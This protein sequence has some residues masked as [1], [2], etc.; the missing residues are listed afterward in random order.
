[1]RARQVCVE[2]LPASAEAAFD[3]VHDY[4]RR[5][6]WDTLL[7]E[8]Y[9]EDGREPGVGAVAS[10]TGRWFVGGLCFR[11]VYVSF[12]R[13]EVAAVKLIHRPPFFEAWAASIRHEPLGP[14]RSRILYT[15][16]FSSRP[17]FLAWLLEPILELAFRIETRRRLRALRAALSQL[18]EQGQAS[19]GGRD[20]R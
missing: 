7:R 1:M 9:V 16:S 18:T 11:T 13:G 15:L 20:E 17:R 19:H 5:L 3:L 12:R 6:A 14:N 2:E 10:C 4:D 8:A